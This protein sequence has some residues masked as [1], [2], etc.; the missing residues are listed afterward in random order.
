MPGKS[1][2][3]GGLESSPV[4]NKQKF[5]APFK[6]RS[7]NSPLKQTKDWFNVKGYLK[8]EQGL[9]P[10]WKGEKTTTTASNISKSIQ[11]KYKKA[12]DWATSDDPLNRR[13][14]MSRE[15][16]KIHQKQKKTSEGKKGLFDFK[17][18]R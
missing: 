4:Y 11:S 2:K 18:N 6:L 3:G 10:D 5:G 12:K 14:G 15:G 8:G 9:I 1:K 13:S 17:K 16:M 7:G